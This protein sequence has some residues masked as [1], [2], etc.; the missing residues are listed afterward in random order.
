MIV[1]TPRAERLAKDPEFKKIWHMPISLKEKA[2]LLKAGQKTVREA[3]KLAGYAIPE[4]IDFNVAPTEEEEQASLAS[5][6]FAPMVAARVNEVTSLHMK[7]MNGEIDSFPW[8]NCRR[9][10][11]VRGKLRGGDGGG[12]A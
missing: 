9:E 6:N 11:F 7:F 5:L 4:V 12:A 10:L 3:A 8:D 2:T 1:E